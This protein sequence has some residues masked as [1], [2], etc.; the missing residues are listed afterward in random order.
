LP[1]RK[2]ILGAVALSATAAVGWVAVGGTA[3]PAVRVEPPLPFRRGGVTVSRIPA[4][5]LAGG[6]KEDGG[7][8]DLLVQNGRISF[9]LGA[10]PAGTP[11]RRTR[12]GALLDVAFKDFEVDEI[13][14]L[15]PVARRAG[16]WLSLSVTAVNV[17][18]EGRYPYLSVE[19]ASKD[20]LLRMRTEFRAA[21]GASKIELLTRFENASTELVH[22][23]E[24]GERTRWP[25]APT[26]APRVGF[27]KMASK[28]EVPWLARRGRRLSYGLAFPQGPVEAQFFFDRIGQ[29]GQETLFRWGDLAPGSSATY[30][31][32]LLVEQGDLGAVA[33]GVFR[34]LGRKVGRIEGRLTP[35]PAWALIE[36]R[37]PDGK[38][39]LAVRSDAS[40]N[41]SLPLPAG[42][43]EVVLR[44]PGGEHQVDVSLRAEGQSVNPNLIAPEPGRLHYV[45]TDE[46]GAALPARM[47]LRGISPTR[48]PELAPFDPGGGAKNIVFSRTGEGQIELPPGRYRIVVTRGPEY[49]VVDQEIELDGQS[50]AAIRAELVRTVETPG[51]IACDFHVHASPSHDSAVSLEDRVLSLL[52][53]GVEIAVSTDHNHVTDYEPAISQLK[54]REQLLGISGVEITTLTWGHFNAYPYPVA[55][56]PPPFSGLTPAE[57]FA[58]VRARAP[59]AVI[60]VNHPRMPG[61]GYFNRIEL[62]NDTGRAEAEE[63]SLDFDAIEVVNGYDLEA[64]SLI[65]KNLREFFALL[66]FGRRFTATG[67]S[68]SHRMTINWAGYPRTYVRVADD[69]PDKVSPKELARAL[70]DGRAQV[71]NGIFLNIAVNGTAGPGDTVTGRRVTLQVQARAPQWADV[72]TLEVW[73]NGALVASTKFPARTRGRV[74]SFETELD[75][76]EDAWLVVVARGE[77]PMSAVFVGR[78]VLPFAFT[79]PVYVD[80]DED[81]HVTPVQAPEPAAV[82]RTP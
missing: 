37:Y 68:D 13:S 19:Q 81:G 57:L 17:E 35:A 29:V 12:Y 46:D 38:P 52:A 58:S 82:P 43:Y 53:E 36:A 74:P 16:K 77:Q 23:L 79:N 31:R 27:P 65:E 72:K 5:G 21:P 51:W 9:V 69:R 71:T 14:E 75:V 60:Q 6:S 39:A 28:A 10:I 25:G 18:T 55:A 76:E 62:D 48:D 64:P 63:A 70:L 15:R 54:A 3:R 8:D 4:G 7:R 41:Y 2:L 44:A 24:L 45:I 73:L 26:F 80:A 47:V 61:V 20:G 22:A 32:E 56:E 67:S 49:A 78:R 40:G 66:N 59:E 50:G 34:A 33:A 30:R 42:D 1:A 11:E